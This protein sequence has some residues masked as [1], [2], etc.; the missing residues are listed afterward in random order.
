MFTAHILYCPPCVYEE[1]SKTLGGWGQNCP[2]SDPPSWLTPWGRQSSQSCTLADWG[3]KI[4]SSAAEREDLWSV[5]HFPN[6]DLAP[7]SNS[8]TS[9]VPLCNT[10]LLWSFCSCGCVLLEWRIGDSGVPQGHKKRL[11]WKIGGVFPKKRFNI[12]FPILFSY[13]SCI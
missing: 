11:R 13:S 7:F 6:Q 4:S 9:P 5:S 12:Y 3:G 2:G 8:A 1:Q 10:F